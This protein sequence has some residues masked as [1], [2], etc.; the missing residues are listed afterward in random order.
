M[1]NPATMFLFYAIHLDDHRAQISIHNFK[2]LPSRQD[3]DNLAAEADDPV[4]QILFDWGSFIKH[5]AKTG[6]P[7]FISDLGPGYLALLGDPPIVNLPPPT[8]P[9]Y[10]TKNGERGVSA[11]LGIL[12]E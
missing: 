11:P 10:S 3:I 5:D 9:S 12:R 4:D 2:H 1:T 6:V 7:Y 8:D